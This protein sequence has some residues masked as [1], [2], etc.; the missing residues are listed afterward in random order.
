MALTKKRLAIMASTVV[1]DV[2]V[3]EFTAI[4][5][6]NTGKMNIAERRGDGEL[7]KEHRDI[8]RED[9]AEF[10]NFAYSVQ[11]DI[12]GLLGL[13][14]SEAVEEPAEEEAAK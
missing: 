13:S 7:L 9:R 11:D 5:D 3:V 2:K 1:N 12:K 10:E 4:M 6:L 8:V 14:D